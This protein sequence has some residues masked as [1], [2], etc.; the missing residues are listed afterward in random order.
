MAPIKI[1]LVGYGAIARNEH[2]PALADED[3]FD[4]VAI[5]S[6]HPPQVEQKVYASLSEMIG[7]EL[8]L[9]AV[10]LCTPPQGRFE[11]AKLALDGG[12]HVMLEKPPGATV[13]EVRALADEARARGLT[14][15]A[16]WH[17]R[18][19]A[20][21]ETARAWLQ[22][23]KI[24]R[25]R[26][27]W[28]EDVERWHPGQEWIWSPPG[29]G[30]FD[31]G[32]N[33][34]SILTR[35]LPDPV[36]LQHAELSY[37]ANRDTPIAASL[38]MSTRGGVPIEAEFDWRQKGEQTWTITVETVAGELKLLHGGSRILLPSGEAASPGVSTLAAE[39]PR[40]YRRFA[41]LIAA[42][43][44]DVDTTPLQLVADAFMCGR[45]VTVERFDG[46]ACP[47]LAPP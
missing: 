37:P 22:N 10:T 26:I 27:E 25:V 13:T 21:V 30:V 45:R 5:A 44:A 46:S 31:P 8:G 1:G 39:Y 7:G 38:R 15:F 16:T 33:A 28:K 18:E 36:A 43:E 29:M 20:G 32:I 11:L 35:I 34:L 3:A 2:L 4:L 14:L 19:A 23:R 9:D 40:L 42:G 12:L 24:L 41:E 47:N 17:S 6:R